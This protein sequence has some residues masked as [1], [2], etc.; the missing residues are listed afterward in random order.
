MRRHSARASNVS[1]IELTNVLKSVA[2]RKQAG[3]AR[4]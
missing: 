1:T 4:A 2:S 3:D